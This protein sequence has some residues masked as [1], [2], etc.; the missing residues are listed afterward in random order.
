M[1]KG[2]DL[3]G[4]EFILPNITSP[5]LVEEFVVYPEVSDQIEQE[6]YPTAILDDSCISEVM[7]NPSIPLVES[8]EAF[9]LGLI[10]TPFGYS[11]VKPNVDIP[12]NKQELHGLQPFTVVKTE[13]QDFPESSLDQTVQSDANASTANSNC[14]KLALVDEQLSLAIL[15]QLKALSAK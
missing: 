11:S 6:S 8:V 12:M 10:E 9:A 1:F 7:R 3:P 5:W 2:L 15:E 14:P 13:C 4:K